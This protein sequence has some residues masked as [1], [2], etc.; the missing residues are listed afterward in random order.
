M[1]WRDGRHIDG[2]GLYLVL[3]EAKCRHPGQPS[4]TCLV[5]MRLEIRECSVLEDNEKLE[6]EGIVLVC[7]ALD[8]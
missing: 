4:R 3:S 2:H 5:L 1:G 8:C 6:T 7:L